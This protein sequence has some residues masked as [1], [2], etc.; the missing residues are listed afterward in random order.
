MRGR[1][2]RIKGG[3]GGEKLNWVYWPE[4]FKLLAGNAMEGGGVAD[5]WRD[6]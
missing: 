4:I 3:C 1:R 2:E 6:R 5:G